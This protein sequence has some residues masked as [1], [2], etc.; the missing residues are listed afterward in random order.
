MI[1]E[2]LKENLL[3]LVSEINASR[4][5]PKINFNQQNKTTSNMSLTGGNGRIWIQPHTEGMD[6]SISGQSL[7]KQMYGFMLSLFRRDCDGY[8]QR[9]ATKG[10]KRQPFWRTSDFMQVKE[11]AFEYAK[12]SPSETSSK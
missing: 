9:N 10:F 11:V 12:T 6:V 5:T 4:V 2:E 1:E 3:V 7:E 8:K